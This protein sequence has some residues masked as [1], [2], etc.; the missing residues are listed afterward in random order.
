MWP[1]EKSINYSLEHGMCYSLIVLLHSH[2][3]ATLTGHHVAYGITPLPNQLR[4]F[5]FQQTI[6]RLQLWS[7]TL[8]LLCVNKSQFFSSFTLL[9]RFEEKTLLILHQHNIHWSNPLIQLSLQGTMIHL[10]EFHTSI[11]GDNG[12][13]IELIVEQFFLF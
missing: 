9:W 10:I 13:N 2:F 12:V 1:C 4:P 3:I 7:F 11:L 6:A 8:P 5:R